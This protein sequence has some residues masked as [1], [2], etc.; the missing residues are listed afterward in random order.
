MSSYFVAFSNDSRDWT[1]LHDGYAEWVSAKYTI[2]LQIDKPDGMFHISTRYIS[3][4]HSGNS[5]LDRKAQK[6]AFKDWL[7]MPSVFYIP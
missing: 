3:R 4:V 2:Q 6:K 1:T 5:P 7:N